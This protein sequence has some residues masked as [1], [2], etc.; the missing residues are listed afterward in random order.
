MTVKDYLLS[1]V[2]VC[3]GSNLTICR[4]SAASLTADCS[5]PLK[6]CQTRTGAPGNSRI[7]ELPSLNLCATRRYLR[8]FEVL[9]AFVCYGDAR[10]HY[11]R[12]NQHVSQ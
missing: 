7:K 2:P 5:L 10:L 1:A 9:Y 3:V 11:M 6:L 12:G 4:L 8:H